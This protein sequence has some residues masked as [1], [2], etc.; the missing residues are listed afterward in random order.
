VSSR[1]F[2]LVPAV[3]VYLLREGVRGP[4]VLLQLRAGTG[5]RDGFWA[6]GAAGHV[7]AGESVHAAAVREAREELGIDLEPADLDPLTT[8]HRTSTPEPIEQRADFFFAARTWAGTPSVR[9]PARSA[10][11]AWSPLDALPDPTVPHEESVLRLLAARRAGGPAI[12]AI[13]THGFG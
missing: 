1:A 12:P 13:T 6:A 7:E 2:R 8:M 5:F 10:G 11:L 3:Y 9:E 4:E